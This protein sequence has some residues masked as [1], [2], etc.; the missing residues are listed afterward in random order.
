MPWIAMKITHTT[1]EVVNKITNGISGDFSDFAIA[2]S[3]QAR[4]G[5]LTGYRL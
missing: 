5:N 1:T 2:I 3:R 4:V